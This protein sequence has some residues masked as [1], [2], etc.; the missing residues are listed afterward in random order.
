VIRNLKE[1]IA[2]IKKS[3]PEGVVMETFYDRTK[4]VNNAINTVSVNLLE[5]ALIVIFIL[6][7]FLGHLRAGLIVASVIPLS[8]LFAVI[9]M[10]LFGVSGNL[11]SLG[12]LDFGLIVDGAVI[13]VEAVMF[14]LITSKKI[15]GNITLTR[16]QM[17]EEVAGASGKMMSAAVFGQVII[18]IV[19]LP[20]LSLAGVEG[21]MFKPMAQTVSFALLGAFLLSVTYVPMITSLLMKR[22]I[23]HKQN[24]S[25]RIMEAL[26]RWYKPLLGKM[27]VIPK[28]IVAI[29][30]ILFATSLL[31]LKGLGGEFIPELEEGDFA[32]DGRIITGSSLS[33]SVKISL[34]AASLLQKSFPEVEKIVTRIGSSEIPTDPM[35]VEMTDIIILLKPKSQWTSAKT[36]DELAEKMRKALEDIPGLST[37]FQFPI[38]MRFNE[39]ISGARQDVVCKIFG[40]NLDTLAAYAAKLGRIINSVNGATDL[41]LETVTGLPQIVVKFNRQVMAHYRLNIDEA[42]EVIQ[43]AFAGQSAGLV[44]EN[45]RRYDLVVRLKENI[46][47]DVSAVENLLIPVPGGTQVPLSQVA[48]IEITEGPSQIQRENAARRIIAGFNVRERDVQSVVEELDKKV[49]AQLHLPAG[50]Y[51]N[52]GGQFEHLAEARNRLTIAVPIALLLIFIILWFAFRSLKNV[53]LIF[54]AIPLSAIGGILFLWL[55]DM[56][57]SI[58]AGI[59]FIALFGVSV[60]NGIVLI[61]EFTRLRRQGIPDLNQIVMEGTSM[62]LRPV[63][64][65]A[66]VASLGFLPMAISHSAG[67]EVQR[68]LATVV[69]GGLITATFLTLIVLPV[70]YVWLHKPKRTGKKTMA[71]VALLAGLAL[72]LP[73]DAQNRMTLDQVLQQASAQNMSL[74]ADRK[75]TEYWRQL[76]TATTDLPHTQLGAEYGKLN[77]VFNDTRFFI[78][79][80]FSLPVVYRHQRDYYRAGEQ[81][82]LA[83]VNLKQQEL[84]K[85]VK[86]VFYNLVDLLERQKL[87]Q[88]LDSTYS[89]FMDAAT[90]RL[91]TGESNILEKS[92]AEAQVLQLKLQQ[93]EVMADI[94]RW[95]QQLQWLLNTGDSI[96]PSYEVAKKPATL[97][98]DTSSV[99]N[100]AAVQWQQEQV[101]LSGAQVNLER[102]KLNPE[103]TVGYSNMS[104]KGYQSKDGVTQQFYDGGDRFSIYQLTLGLPIFSKVT[105]ARIRAARVHEEMAQLQVSITKGLLNSQWMQL[106]EEFKK[107]SEQVNYYEQNGLPQAELM[108][109]NARLAFE[110]G[111]INYV[112]WTMLMSNAVNIELGYLQTLHSLNETI[113]EL[114]YLT[115]K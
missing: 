40:E 4:V 18:L 60:L 36:S 59:G 110:K 55:R 97:N 103:F 72:S 84:H 108:T 1:R 102:S 57:F 46:R 11:M 66:S 58:S 96:L 34:Q 65:T 81:A 6:V 38:Q 5:G 90:L 30:V 88:R 69:I 83:Q 87:L 23:H 47:T 37:G 100:H 24:I 31:V 104:I 3:L 92:A 61:T 67:A 89:R 105:K 93:R 101:K 56:P 74:Q 113:I 19:Y 9:M 77:S 62:R 43:A 35:P 111:S 99:S 10:R 27:L 28:M 45:E 78:S 12:A 73:A 42:N 64:M 91:K 13:I 33:Q 50:Y 114:E 106:T 20:I 63:L 85:Q 52:Y 14:Q 94:R 98:I 107:F 22:K 7:L 17:D 21:K 39:L 49:N 71:T 80:S 48:K 109:R 112:E 51:I 95:Q 115:G 44:Y 82:A 70:L 32:V 25:G 76:Q 15:T 8:L 53:L 16:V 86:T 41:Y 79:Q 54:S 68:P 2:Q 75:G 26:Q 29:T